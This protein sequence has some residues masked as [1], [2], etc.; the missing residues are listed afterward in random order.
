VPPRV[1]NA[2][3]KKGASAKARKNKTALC[4]ANSKEKIGRLKTKPANKNQNNPI[5]V[6]NTRIKIHIK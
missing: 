4:A 1:R 5:L 3:T 2:T 6:I